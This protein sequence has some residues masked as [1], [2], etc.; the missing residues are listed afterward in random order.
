MAAE[1]GTSLLSQ[2][3]SSCHPWIYIPRTANTA[4]TGCIPLCSGISQ[5]G[6]W[7]LALSRLSLPAPHLLELLSAPRV[8]CPALPCP[9]HP[10][11]VKRPPLSMAD[12][13]RRSLGVAT[14]LH[15]GDAAQLRLCPALFSPRAQLIEDGSVDHKKWRLIFARD[16]QRCPQAPRPGGAHLDYKVLHNTHVMGEAPPAQGTTKIF[17]LK[18]EEPFS[19]WSAWKTRQRGDEPTGAGRSGTS[20]EP[21]GW[22]QD[23]AAVSRAGS[24]P[25]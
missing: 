23:R 3:P 14:P 6:F 10:L 15:L 22:W 4:L 8:V 5:E 9:I 7:V 13:L 25:C 1:V 2:G 18:R 20:R 19:S 21:W 12:G 17:L 24:R 11:V 16:P